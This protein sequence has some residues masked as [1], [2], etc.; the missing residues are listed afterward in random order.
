VYKE[1]SLKSYFHIQAKNKLK[2]DELYS[3]KY[4]A[5]NSA[6]ASGKS[7]GA[8]FVSAKQAIKIKLN[9][10][11]VVW[12]TRHISALIQFHLV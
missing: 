9:Q 5:T 10:A 3:V 8:R 11:S 6:S 4:P 7:K 2:P 1:H 12:Q